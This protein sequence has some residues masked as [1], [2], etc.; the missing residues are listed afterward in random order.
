MLRIRFT[1][2]AGLCFS[3]VP[4]SGF[5]ADWPQFRGANSTGI[6]EEKLPETWSPEANV[7]WKVKIPG[8]AWSSPIVSGDKVFVT[9]A[10]TENQRKPSSSQFGGGGRGPGGPGGFTP[11]KPGEILPTFLQDRLNL[12]AEQKKSVGEIQTDIDSQLSELLTEEQQT[13]LKAPPQGG[14]GPGGGGPGA[15][16]QVDSAD[17]VPC[18]RVRFLQRHCRSHLS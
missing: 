16:G 14:R 17:F 15:A 18:S 13:Q 12:T 11:P 3:A 6:A 2:L 5:A 9:T 4:L 1:I 10:V 8:V 7:Q